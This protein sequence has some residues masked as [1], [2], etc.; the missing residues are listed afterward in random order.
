MAAGLFGALGSIGDIGNQEAEGRQ[1]AHEEIVRRLAEQQA[2]QTTTLN[3]QHIR[4]QIATA[5]QNE[6]IAAQPIAVGPSY[7]SGGKT[8]QRMQDPLTGAF[9]V[10]ELPGGAP[11]TKIENTAR[12]L[13]AL[14][15]SEE[16][17]I[18]TAIKLATG[19]QAEKREVVADPNSP[20]GWSAAYMDT[21]GTELW[22]QPGIIP[23]RQGAPQETVRTT[24][25]PVTNLTTRSVTVR[26]PMFT[27]GAGVQAPP[28][29]SGGTVA[30]RAASGAPG[31]PAAARSNAIVTGL[32]TGQMPATMVTPNP[33]GLVAA[34][35][36]PIWTRPTIQNADG[37]HST[38]YTTSFKDEDGDG[39][40]V[41]VP[42]VVNGRF[43]T[44]DGKKPPEGSD[45]EKAMFTAAWKHYK[46]TGENL[47]KFDNAANANA[48]SHILHNRGAAPPTAQAKPASAPAGQG[49][50]AVGPYKGIQLTE[51]GRAI[52]PA[53]P[54]ITDSV[55]QAAQDILDGRDTTKIPAKVRFLG[56]SVARAYGWKGQGSLTPAQQ[57]QIQQV[58]N[59]LA[60]L[61][62]PNFLKLFDSTFGRLRMSTVPLDPTGEGGL[63]GLTAAI[64]RGAISQDQ[65]EYMNALTRL[66]G[67]I[68][69][70]RG[71]TGAN[72]S[73][74]TADRLLAELPN[75][76][77]TKN[78]KDAANKITRLR[79]EVAIIKR[80]GYFLPDEAAP[81]GGG[82]VPAGAD[83][84]LG[85]NLPAVQ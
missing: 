10:K 24:T 34:G 26:K 85:L 50:V 8:L 62:N 59:S 56:E 77:N 47:G 31:A 80:L 2:Q 83:N 71:F 46:D 84:P 74:A 15:L 38:E 3:Q 82:D 52:I 61:S 69:G 79:Q 63:A 42:T 1:L 67:V 44:P 21:E 4:Q 48:Y 41:L 11:E 33:K 16:E 75:F 55:R 17:S 23:P 19:K 68:G 20:T 60:T 76:A 9:T 54:G 14:G 78:S 18:S 27:P 58:D 51:D 32:A 70:I 81:K 30:P 35:N 39:S 64:N 36:L 25:D 43:L 6:K 49:T 13:K 72:N 40:E 65:A 57:M 45:A 5:A 53:R 28:G 22:R 73:N 7:V 29:A 12:G 66:R 37:T